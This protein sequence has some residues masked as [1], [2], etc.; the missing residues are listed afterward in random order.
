MLNL[1]AMTCIFFQ[2]S[3]SMCQQ[4]GCR[5]PWQLNGWPEE[6]CCELACAGALLRCAAVECQRCSGGNAH[7][8]S[9]CVHV[10]FKRC[11]KFS[12]CVCL[13]LCANLL[14]PG[15]AK[16]ILSDVQYCFIVF[17]GQLMALHCLSRCQLQTLS[18]MRWSLLQDRLPGSQHY[19]HSLLHADQAV[20]A[21]WW[22]ACTSGQATIDHESFMCV[23]DCIFLCICSK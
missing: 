4:A 18:N 5:L 16:S 10:K 14:H 21:D 12:K 11:C 19:R 17:F 8:A 1:H 13:C 2:C 22:D 9:Q 15:N 20:N 3:L 7:I 6:R 23:Q